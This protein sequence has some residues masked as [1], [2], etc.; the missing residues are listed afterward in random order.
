M[1][2]K[3]FVCE[4]GRSFDKI[5]GMTGHQ[6]NCQIHKNAVKQKKEARR[7]PNGMF[8]C[9]NPDCGKEHDGNFES[10]R[11]CSLHCRRH[12]VS[13]MSYQT[14]KK[15]GTF[16]CNFNTDHTHYKKAEY[17]RWT[18]SICNEIFDTRAKLISH[19]KSHGFNSGYAWNKG[20][21]KETCKS[22]ANACQKISDGVKRA[23][24]EGKCNGRAKTPEAELLRRKR[25]SIAALNR[26]TP[27]VC[28][29]T[30]PYVCIDGSIVKLDS[31]Y[32]RTV[33]KLLDEHH[34]KWNRPK[35]LV[36]FDKKNIQ[37]HYFPDFYLVDYDVYL[38]PKND[39]CFKVQKEKIDY[40]IAH[41][42]NCFFLNK[43]QLTWE[44]INSI[45]EQYS[46]SHTS[47]AC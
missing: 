40:I 22:I 17:G 14:K 1:E 33:A 21:T 20:L 45:L 41:Y 38:D 34:V 10:G 27:S 5:R 36:W 12:Y 26:T 4:C 37:H 35:P 3:K 30:E 24:A 29:K 44:F 42:S 39:Y 7:L 23:I 32:E 11:F 46:R 9:E 19:R 31:S 47:A 25:M 15:N 43:N 6:A 8:K 2:E 18:C 13:L 28:K 16:K